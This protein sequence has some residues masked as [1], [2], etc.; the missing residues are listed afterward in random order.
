MPSR[1][2]TPLRRTWLFLLVLPMAL[3]SSCGRDEVA[4]G[5]IVGPS[6]GPRVDESLLALAVIGGAPVGIT[7]LFERMDE[8]HLWVRWANLLP[9]H[10]AEAV[11]FNPSG[12]EVASSIVPIDTGPSDQVTDFVLELTPSSTY[13]RW[14]VQLYLDGV[15]QRSHVFDVVDVP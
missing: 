3:L 4:S 13:G 11:W 2:H 15:L 9:P 7:S 12:S 6:T 10:E 14:Q 1:L 8:V 5:N